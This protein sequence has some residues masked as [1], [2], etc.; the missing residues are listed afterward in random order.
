MDKK[1]DYDIALE[2]PGLTEISNSYME[3]FLGEILD[4]L[5]DIELEL[6]NL[7]MD[8]GN[9][10]SLNSVYCSF[11]TIRGLS[12]LL[13]DS[14]STKIAIATEELLEAVRKYCPVISKTIINLILDSISFIRKLNN[15]PKI[16][17]DSKFSGEV[18]RHLKNLAINKDD[19]LLEVRQPMA[20]ESRIGEILVQ[21]GA[22]A[23][24]EVEDVLKK[25]T[26]INN[27][28][29]FGEIVLR[30]KKVDAS[31]IIKAIRM[32]KVRN[33]GSVDQYV[34]IPL[35]RLDQII[36]LIQNVSTLYDSVKDE[37]VLRFGSNDALTIE[38]TK[39]YHLIADIRNILKEL[40]MVTLQQAFQKLTRLVCS[41][42]EENHLEVMFST[43]GENIEVDKEIAD[44]IALPL[45]D[46]IWLLLEK[47]YRNSNGNKKR[48]GNIEVV[49]Y[50]DN[51][52]VHID[53]TGDAVVDLEELRSDNKYIENQQK[54]SYLKS[55]LEVD[56]MNG[57]GVRISVIIQ[58]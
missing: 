30:E 45:G 47:A 53:I 39:A 55:K 33:T 38:S 51:N 23:L 3:D 4:I 41:I 22:L 46:L 21:E 49:A 16:I 34:R 6:V 20:R 42:I 48:I 15:N 35:E 8:P 43:L 26:S 2:I 13:N 10:E 1:N 58:R 54:L 44:R 37:A 28:M 25:Q 50:E 14:T 31:D 12:G 5:D 29:K 24:S 11:H 52:T 57:E 36:G 27:K 32:Q 9:K 19:I 18:G 40:R 56:D 7:E 17:D